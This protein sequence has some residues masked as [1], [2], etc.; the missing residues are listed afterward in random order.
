MSGPARPAAGDATRIG[1]VS[2]THGTLRPEL[3]SRLEGV[4]RILHAGDVGEADLLREL[5]LIA[6]VTAVYGNTDSWEL[7]Q[8]LPAVARVEEEARRIVVVHGHDLGSPTPAKLAA[9]F[10]DAD[11]VVYGHTHRALVHRVGRTLVVNPGAAGP[12][13]FRVR[14]SLAILT[15]GREGDTV[16]VVEL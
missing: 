5:E 7:R 10:P 9:A 11:I 2:D 6:P 12:A 3:L 1:L 4:T 16:E 15:L 14:P 13:R 8:R